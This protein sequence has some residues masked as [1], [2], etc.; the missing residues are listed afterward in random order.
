AAEPTVAMDAIIISRRSIPFADLS[1][2]M[3]SLV[4]VKG[5]CPCERQRHARK[6]SRTLGDDREEH[7]RH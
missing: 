1:G 5:N 7:G 6:S 2:M 3:G 4:I